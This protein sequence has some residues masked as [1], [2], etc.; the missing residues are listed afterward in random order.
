MTFAKDD[1]DRTFFIKVLFS[2]RRNGI[3]CFPYSRFCQLIITNN[4]YLMSFRMIPELLLLSF[5]IFPDPCLC[6]HIYFV[7]PHSYDSNKLFEGEKVINC[8]KKAIQPEK[9][10]MCPRIDEFY[11]T[12]GNRNL[13]LFLHKKDFN[14]ELC[15]ISLLFVGKLIFTI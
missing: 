12:L 6:F 7:Q 15:R 2:E 5:L 8:I 9:K 11:I 10:V 3:F 1:T 13:T 4:L 14:E